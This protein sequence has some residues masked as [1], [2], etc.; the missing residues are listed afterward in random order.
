MRIFIRNEQREVKE[1]GVKAEI[2]ETWPEVK[3]SRSGDAES[4]PRALGVLGGEPLP[5]LSVRKC[6]C[7]SHPF[8]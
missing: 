4:S 3:G 7:Y 2:E 5:F 8:H 1:N 6:F